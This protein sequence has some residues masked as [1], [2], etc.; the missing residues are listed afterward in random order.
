MLNLNKHFLL[1]FKNDTIKSTL[2]NF[3]Q[4]A[5]PRYYIGPE[6]RPGYKK[7]RATRI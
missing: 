7:D 4:S 6:R 2:D 3:M 1:N 5:Y